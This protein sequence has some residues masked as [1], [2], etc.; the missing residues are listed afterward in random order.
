MSEEKKVGATQI[1]TAD[2]NKKYKKRSQ[3]KEIWTRLKRSKAAIFGLVL[4]IMIIVVALS[5]DLIADY[6]TQVKKQNVVNRLQPPSSEHWFGTDE[7]GRDIFARIVHGSRLS[8]QVGIIAIGIALIIGGSLG[9]I[10]GY[11]GGIIDN[12]IMRVM[13]I[14][15]AIPSLLLA[16][17]IVSALGGS[18][19]NLM[20]SIGLSV[21]PNYARIVRSA[22]LSVKDQEF[23]EAARAVGAK[24]GTIILK[25][26]LPN[27]MAPIIVQ[28]TLN[29][30]TAILSTSS[31]SFIGLGVQ[32][33]APEWG[34]MLA[35]GRP[36]LRDAPH[37]CIFPGIA[38]VLTILSLNLLGDGLRDA[39][40]P[41][42]KQ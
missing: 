42:L 24:N 1:E 2:I 40:D 17:A 12:V 25:E 16:I 31:L 20:I 23:I 15:L 34:N 6:E 4:F 14:F 7:Y 22:V 32:P 36:F 11:Y 41:K 37:L 3:F 30:A 29:V 19:I 27:C 33:P 26:V 28:V 35:G 39:L 18:N 5:A 10:A 8:L 13:D 9:A 21:V 38:I